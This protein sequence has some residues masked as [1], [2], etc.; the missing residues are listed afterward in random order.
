MEVLTGQNEE[1]SY[2]GDG[3][4]KVDLRLT[5]AREKEFVAGIKAL[6]D[7]RTK[8]TTTAIETFNQKLK[9]LTTYKTMALDDADREFTTA[10]RSLF[11]E[12]HQ[13]SARVAPPSD[14]KPPALIGDVGRRRAKPPADE[15]QEKKGNGVGSGAIPDRLAD[16]LKEKPATED[17]KLV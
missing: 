2:H 4:L 14:P 16:V 9:D 5:P 6:R 7:A 11:L 8:K 1:F 17:N 13:P 10:M 3:R 12:F 15:T